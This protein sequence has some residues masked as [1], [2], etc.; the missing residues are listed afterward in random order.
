[1]M[2]NDYV[3]RGGRKFYLSENAAIVM[4]QAGADAVPYLIRILTSGK[5][6]EVHVGLSCVL[7][8][9]N[10]LESEGKTNMLSRLSLDLLP[11]VVFWVTNNVIETSEAFCC[12]SVTEKADLTERELRRYLPAPRGSASL[13]TE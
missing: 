11:Y 6:S 3:V 12:L 8:L 10:S 2:K 7:S 4:T 1:M 5:A 9:V 13:V